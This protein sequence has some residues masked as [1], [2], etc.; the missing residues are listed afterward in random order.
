MISL[1]FLRQFHFFEYAVF[2]L[3][4]SFL[5]IYL[6]SPLLSKIFQKLKIDIPRKNWLF[7]TLPIG[8]FSHLFIGRITPMTRNF[9]DTSAHYLLKII[10]LSLLILGTRGIKIIKK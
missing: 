9:L 1:E 3:S 7:L 6:L 2:D 4:L 5:G 8:I 10:I